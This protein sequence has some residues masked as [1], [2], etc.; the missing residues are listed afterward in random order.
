MPTGITLR[1]DGD[2]NDY[3]GKGLSGG[4]LIVRPPPD[5][6]PD[7]VAEDNIIAGNVILYGA[8]G[9]EAFLR[10]VVGERFC[11][12]NSG[13]TAVVEGVG[14]HGCEYMTG[15][16][17]VVLGP[18]GRNF[19]AG[20]SGGIAFVYDPDDTFFRRLNREMVDLDPLDDDDVELLRRRSRTHQSETD[21][22]GRGAH[23]RP[24]ARRG[25]PLQEGD[26][27]GLQAGARGDA[28][29]GG[30]GDGR[31][32]RSDHGGVPMGDVRPGF[33]KHGRELP[34]RRPV[35]VR[36]LDW[37]EV[38]EPFPDGELRTQAA[39]CMDCGIPFC[40]NGCPL[41]NLI[42]DWNDLVYRDHWRDAIDRLHA[43]N[44][45]PEFTGRLCPA[46]CEAACVL[47]INQDPVTIKQVEVAI[48][49]RAWD[50][51]WVVPV[52][53][54]V[55]DRQAGRRRRLRPRRAGRRAAA[56]ARRPRRRRV[57]AGRPHRRAAA[58]RHPRVQ[59]GEAAPR[60]S[61]R[62]D[63]GRGHRVPHERERR[64]QRRRSASSTASTPSCSPA[65]PRAWRDLPIPG[66]ELAGIYQAMEYLPWANKVQEGDLDGARRSPPHGK[67]VVIIG[68][69]D[70][71][72]DCLGT[73]DPPRRGVDPPV[74]DH[75]PAARRAARRQPVA[76]VAADLPHLVGPRGGR[77]ARLL[78]E[79]RVL[80]RRRR[81]QRRAPCAP[82][83]SRWSTAA[84]RRSR[85]PTSSCRA[86]SCCSPWASSARSATGLLEQLGVELNERG[87]VAR[88]ARFATNVDGVFVCGDMGRGQSLIV[89]AIAE[90]RS[91]AAAVDEYLMG[92][93]ALPAPITP[94]ARPLT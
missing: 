57:R 45:F 11:V 62:A 80:P 23:P 6:A 21:S 38:Y 18:T 60:P 49:D 31:R 34:T 86:S 58:L 2:A 76:D 41:G 16:R 22:G 75:A 25:A 17:V 15:G 68:G 40:N 61:P 53:P 84:S 9:G 88:D 29:R 72:A 39:R 46:P 14:D 92:E 81:R 59:D 71:G 55:E 50:E 83:R 79:H 37:Q 66:R 56:D 12:R 4:R 67:H 3:F 82:T 73:V 26:A 30:A 64:R 8:T 13:A 70:T 77:R 27:E 44:N 69:G 10:G 33:L 43:T 52:L 32:G 54:S 36:L 91:C 89:W 48:I 1:L 63:G 65:A 20:M 7:F 24:L 85:A 51:G 5:V 19:G 35:P 42:P 47:G 87:N 94:D 78:G 74:R 90:G 93:T 28:H